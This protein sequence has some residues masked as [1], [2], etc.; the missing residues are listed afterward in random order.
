LRAALTT[1]PIWIAVGW[2]GA[3]VGE[4]L[5]PADGPTPQRAGL[6]LVGLSLAL[7]VLGGCAVLAAA[8]GTD[9]RRPTI[10]RCVWGSARFLPAVAAAA[11][12]AGLLWGG[13]GRLIDSVLAPSPWRPRYFNDPPSTDFSGYEILLFGGA[14]IFVLLIGGIALGERA[15]GQIRALRGLCALLR[16]AHAS[17]RGFRRAVARLAGADLQIALA[18]LEDESWRRDL[19]PS[20][21]KRCLLAATPE[22]LLDACA[23]WVPSPATLFTAAEVDRAVTRIPVTARLA[24]WGRAFSLDTVSGAEATRAVVRAGFRRDARGL[25]R[26]APVDALQALDGVPDG[27]VATLDRDDVFPL[28]AH[29][30]AEVRERAVSLLGRVAGDA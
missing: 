2:E 15:E 9:T 1:S 30:S 8:T 29:P 16:A 25:L 14:G 7:V 24:A 3:R 4:W 23:R 5:I 26:S 17:Q 20:D 21:L 6:A 18:A 28:L 22:R 19:A 10:A 13:G 12:L 11:G 27:L